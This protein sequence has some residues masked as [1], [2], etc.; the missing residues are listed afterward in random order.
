MMKVSLLLVSFA[1]AL[2]LLACG[3]IKGSSTGGAGEDAT[4]DGDATSRDGGTSPPSTAACRTPTPSEL[5]ANDNGGGQS[6][7][8]GS[9]EGPEVSCSL[10]GVGVVLSTRRGLNGASLNVSSAL[11]DAGTLFGGG[12]SVLS[13]A[14]PGT[15]YVSGEIFLKN[16]SPGTYTMA[17]EGLPD[18]STSLMVSYSTGDC[19]DAE[20]PNCIN[21]CSSSCNDAGESCSCQALTPGSAINNTQFIAEPAIDGS[22]GAGSWTVSLTSVTPYSGDAGIEDGGTNYVVHGSISANLTM[23]DASTPSLPEPPT[24]TNGASVILKF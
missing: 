3:G 12:C 24:S 19:G 22:G 21:G 15:L 4:N 8:S 16:T 9:I 23:T 14:V 10:C 13:N 11:T 2:L 20:A 7:G 17:M 18:W 5:L 1:F 6:V